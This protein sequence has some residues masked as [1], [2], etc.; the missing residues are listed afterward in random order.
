[1]RNSSGSCVLYDVTVAYGNVSTPDK[2]FC[3]SIN[4][5]VHADGDAWGSPPY[6]G[7]TTWDAV[8]GR[9]LVR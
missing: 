4:N 9:I 7:G 2:L 1:M 3:F 8:G 6:A 5:T